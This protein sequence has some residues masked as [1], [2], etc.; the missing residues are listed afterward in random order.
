[1]GGSRGRGSGTRLDGVVEGI[2]LSSEPHEGADD[3]PSRDDRIAVSLVAVSLLATPSAAQVTIGFQGLVP[4]GSVPSY[5]ES[6]YTVTPNVGNIY[7]ADEGGGNTVMFPSMA[8]A[9][10]TL[11]RD[12]G[13]PF[14]LFNVD[15]GEINGSVGT[16]TV[17]FVG[18]L[19]LG[20]AVNQTFVTDGVYGRRPLP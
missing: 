19:Y 6:G 7:A 11:V 3:G 20:G 8:G 18:Y 16:Q 14:D 13:L 10:F 17:Q 9:V 4:G 5:S 15:L 12:D 2:R 1:M